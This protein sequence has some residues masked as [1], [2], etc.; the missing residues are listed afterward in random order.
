MVST[1]S[2]EALAETSTLGC[3]ITVH[4][5]ATLVAHI[6]KFINKM[7]NNSLHVAVS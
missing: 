6:L 4:L 1:P 5:V 3:N 7:V 2:R